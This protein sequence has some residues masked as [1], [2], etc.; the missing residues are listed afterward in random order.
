MGAKKSAYERHR[1]PELWLVDTAADEV[2][3]FR[4][5]KPPAPTFDVAEELA[6]GDTLTSPLLPGFVLALDELFPAA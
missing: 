3:I 5:S 4:R 6:R 2:L 1:L